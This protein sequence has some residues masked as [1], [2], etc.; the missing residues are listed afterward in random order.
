MV[1]S[2]SK[3][4]L[5]L[6][7]STKHRADLI[8]DDLEKEMHAYLA[9][10]CRR[11]GSQAFL[12]GGTGNHIHIACTLPRTLTISKLLEEIKKVHLHG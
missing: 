9:D 5:H 4:L 2:L 12:V 3:V 1:Q 8:P 6:V 7:F 10:E 11:Q